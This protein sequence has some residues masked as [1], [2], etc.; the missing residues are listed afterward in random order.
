MPAGRVAIGA[1]RLVTAVTVHAAAPSGCITR[2]ALATRLPRAAGAARAAEEELAVAG[3]A[4]DARDP[5]PPACWEAANYIAALHMAAL[6]HFCASS[7]GG[8]PLMQLLPSAALPAPPRAPSAAAPAAAGGA[9]RRRSVWVPGQPPQR[10]PP[11]GAVSV[12]SADE[13]AERR[14]RQQQQH[15]HQRP[16][17]GLEQ[18]Q[19]SAY[20]APVP[21][22]GSSARTTGVAAPVPVEFVASMPP[23]AQLPGHRPVA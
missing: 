3:A 6:K 23:E 19:Q 21:V 12:A 18:W 10:R 16:Q 13:P 5:R 15:Q 2:V 14:Q 22:G 9:A 17:Q 11:G 1:D 8:H 4:H 20:V 7:G